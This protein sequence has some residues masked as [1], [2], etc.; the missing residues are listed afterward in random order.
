MLKEK[1]LYQVILKHDTRF[2]KKDHIHIINNF[3]KE[4]LYVKTFATNVKVKTKIH[5]N[6]SYNKKTSMQFESSKVI[7]K[8]LTHRN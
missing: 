5:K 6:M 3:S 7:A 4:V 2:W 1:V 8:L